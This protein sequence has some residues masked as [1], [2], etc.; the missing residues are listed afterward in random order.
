MNPK[1]AADVVMKFQRR[2]SSP[3]VSR[4][5]ARRAA[6]RGKAILQRVTPVDEGMAQKAWRDRATTRGAELIN[7]APYIGVLEKGARPF[8]PPFEPI[9]RWVARQ[10]QVSLSGVEIGPGYGQLSGANA[11][12]EQVQMVRAIAMAVIR[13]IQLKGFEPRNFVRGQLKKLGKIYGEE[14]VA[15]MQEEGRKLRR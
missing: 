6:K 15:V 5:A 9:F 10:Q 7:D 4:R 12:S 1:Q 3:V 2:I 11:S 8:T 14:M 13:K